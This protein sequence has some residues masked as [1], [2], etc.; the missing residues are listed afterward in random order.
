MEGNI[1][2]KRRLQAGAACDNCRRRKSRCDGSRPRC[3]NCQIRS[4]VCDYDD[5]HVDADP[6]GP[7]QTVSTRKDSKLSSDFRSTSSSAATHESGPSRDCYGDTSTFNFGVDPSHHEVDELHAVQHESPVSYMTH[8]QTSGFRNGNPTGVIASF[9]DLPDR[10]FADILVDA[11]F[12]R[13]HRLYPFV[14]EG[15][16]ERSMSRCGIDPLLPEP[17]CDCHG[18]AF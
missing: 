3:S 5:Q 14:H 10:G 8:N 6:N 12:N 17:R 16:S 18:L 13:M 15:A 2:K 9:F 7:E 11:Y 1:S 4:I